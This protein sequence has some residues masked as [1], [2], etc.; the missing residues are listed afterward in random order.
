MA[1]INEIFP[2]KY[3]SADDIGE[4]K[5]VLTIEK[6]E[7]TKFKGKNGEEEIKPVIFFE[8]KKK[9]FVSNKTN[10]KAIAAVLGTFETDE[11]V[12]KKIRLLTV[13]VESFGEMGTAIRVSNKPVQTS[14]PVSKSP[15]NDLTP[16]DIPF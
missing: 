15:S 1:N 2:S 10:G 3:L 6:V 4:S 8:G 13:E 12:G 14:A 7:L 5:P 11:W 9:A 16:D